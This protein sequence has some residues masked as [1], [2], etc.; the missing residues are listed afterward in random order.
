MAIPIVTHPTIKN[1]REEKLQEP[2]VKMNI[3]VY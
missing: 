2:P 1:I 3:H